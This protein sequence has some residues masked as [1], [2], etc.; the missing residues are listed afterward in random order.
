[1]RVLLLLCLLIGAFSV[2][3]QR[4]ALKHNLLYDVALTPNLALEWRL[5]DRWT[6]QTEVGFNPFPLSDDVEHKWRHVL[7][8][9]EAKY[10]FCT[11]FARDFIGVNVA[12]SHF[13]VAG[14]SYP[15]GWLYSE[16]KDHRFQ[17]DMVAAGVSYGWH[18]IVSPHVGFELEAGCDVGYAWYDKFACERCGALL[19]SE[20]KWFAVPKAAVNLV[21]MLK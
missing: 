15:I 20:R 13:N 1:M 3:A 8:D 5:A 10:W 4:V 14:G 11:A 2:S 18:F 9:L 16:V 17:G 6:M 12:Y 19:D 7:V 21:I